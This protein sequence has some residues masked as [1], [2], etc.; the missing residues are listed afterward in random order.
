MAIDLEKFK[1]K[2]TTTPTNTGGGIDLSQFRLKSPIP[3]KKEVGLVGSPI[4]A[5]KELGTGI[6][7]SVSK[8][9]GAMETRDTQPNIARGVLRN[10]GQIAGGVG[11]VAFEGLK[12]LAPKFVE[13]LAKKGIQEVAKTDVAQNALV[14]YEEF[15]K[16]HPEAAKDVEAL[17]NIGSLIP[18]GK[19]GQIAAKGITKAGQ[20]AVPLAKTG[21]RAVTEPIGKSKVFIFGRNPVSSVDDVIK[22]ADQAISKP[23]AIRAVSEVATAKPS[24]SQRW[25]GISPDIKNRI[26]GKQDKLKE[27]FDVAHARNN[28]DTLPTPLEYGAVKV[29]DTVSQME[30]LLNETGG[31]IGSFRQKVGTF[32][33]NVDQ[34][35]RIEQSFLKELNDLNL[36]VSNGIIKQKPGTITRVGSK[37]DI[38]VLQELLG[39]F[40]TIKEAPNLER[41]IDMRNVFDRKINFEK[42]AREVSSAIDPV[43][44]NVR[45]Q[46]A[47]VGAEIV[48]KSEAANLKKYAD[49][50]EAYDTLRSFTERRAGAEFLLKQVLSERGRVPRELMDTIKEFTGVDLMDDAVMSSIATD[51]ISNSRQKG[52]F[53]QEITKAGLDASRVLRGDTR[54]AIELMFNFLKKGLVNEE[55][56][57]LKAAGEGVRKPSIPRKK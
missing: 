52:L 32:K 40:S 54:G 8:R 24:I 34:V 29:N 12:F 20:R 56:Q 16:K 44:R 35:G 30:K 5:V 43:S 25:A 39:D 42:S 26:V 41:L 18:I 50:I 33:A 37:N 31:K 22:Q 13:D 1:L 3:V 23:S 14:K 57:F 4:E 15:T 27:Y 9:V 21:V 45:K 36:T 11:D 2:P 48:G 55:K 47:D 28:F 17:F 53:R 19:G 7:E 10:V 6:K 49:F 38:K 51:L 46:I